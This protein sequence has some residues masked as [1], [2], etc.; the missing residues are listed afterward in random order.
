M[1]MMATTISRI[2]EDTTTGR[3]HFTATADDGFV[4]TYRTNR[5][6]R[7]LEVKRAT[8][9]WEVATPAQ[10]DLDSRPH[11]RERLAKVLGLG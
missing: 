10:I 11:R 1:V 8:G 3:F 4:S 6:G 9:W 7:G 5:A 2:T